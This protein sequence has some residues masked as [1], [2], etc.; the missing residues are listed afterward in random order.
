MATIVARS[1]RGAVKIYLRKHRP[2]KG[3]N[4]HAKPR[5]H[6]EWVSFKVY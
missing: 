1:L 4:I 3:A 2:P 6:G 5:G